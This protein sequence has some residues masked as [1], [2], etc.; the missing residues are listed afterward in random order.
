MPDFR[1]ATV[2]AR[3]QPSPFVPRPFLRSAEASEAVR[4]LS[5]L[6][7]FAGRRVPLHLAIFSS[8]LRASR[9][10]TFRGRQTC[11]PVR[12]VPVHAV[13]PTVLPGPARETVFPIVSLLFCSATRGGCELAYPTSTF[14]FSG[15]LPQFTRVTMSQSGYKRSAGVSCKLVDWF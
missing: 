15:H 11:C 7:S 3:P 10:L 6:Y 5:A 2:S 9:T 4:V 12:G 1:S 13:P 14:L 8:T